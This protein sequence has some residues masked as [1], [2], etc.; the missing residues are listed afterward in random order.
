MRSLLF[1]G[2]AAMAFAGFNLSAQETKSGKVSTPINGKDLT[3]WKVKGDAKKHKWSIGIAEMD[4]A[5]K[6]QLIVKETADSKGELANGNGGGGVDIATEEKFG[7][8]VLEIELMV[9]QGSNSG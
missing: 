6:N 8:C 9:P 3:G 7:D 4:P 1:A 2:L 5:K